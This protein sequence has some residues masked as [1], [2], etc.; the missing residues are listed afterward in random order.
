MYGSPGAGKS[1]CVKFPC[2]T[3]GMK[4]MTCRDFGGPCDEEVTGN[5]FEEIGNKCKEHVMERIKSG[6]EAHQAAAAKMRDATPEEQASMMAEYRK[7]FDD[8][9]DA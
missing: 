3:C 5:S 4:K 6:D 8:T 2:Y 9:P 7:K 1:P